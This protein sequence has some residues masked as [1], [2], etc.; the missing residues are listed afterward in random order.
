MNCL[1]ALD[2]ATSSCPATAPAEG[3]PTCVV[4]VG[5]WQAAAIHGKVFSARECWLFSTSH[6]RRSFIE[7]EPLPPAPWFPLAP[8]S[9]S[10]P[11]RPVHRHFAV[12][13]SGRTA[14]SAQS[15]CLR[16]CELYPWLCPDMLCRFLG[17]HALLCQ[18][19]L[20]CF[21]HCAGRLLW[22]PAPGSCVAGGVGRKRAPGLDSSTLQTL[23]AVIWVGIERIENCFH[24]H[25]VLKLT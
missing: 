1:A 14:A 5:S 19:V 8:V 23:V 16:L 7:T 2:G 18:N 15:P 3:L 10:L 9:R 20:L 12:P 11:R 6:C 24:T 22:S 25:L 21:P 17:T 4:G 13:D